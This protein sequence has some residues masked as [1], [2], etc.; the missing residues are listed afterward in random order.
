[1]RVAFVK[2]RACK[3]EPQGGVETVLVASLPILCGDAAVGSRCPKLET[4]QAA[5]H[6]KG[7]PPAQSALFPKFFQFRPCDR[8]RLCSLPLGPFWGLLGS[9]RGGNFAGFLASQRVGVPRPH[10][11]GD[12]SRESSLRV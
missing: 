10:I 1:M 12:T 9:V 6:R 5:G 3:A 11:G 8:R 4:N 2:R 7:F